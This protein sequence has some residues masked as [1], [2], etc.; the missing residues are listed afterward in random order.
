VARV[1]LLL[2]QVDRLT[3]IV[4]MGLER[5]TWPPPRPEDVDLRALADRVVHFLEPSFAASE[6]TVSLV[7]TGGWSNP[8]RARCDPDM[9][10]QILLNLLKNA[11][12]AARPAG[13][14]RVSVGAVGDRAELLVADDGPGLSREMREQLFSPFA[15]TKA[16]G[17]G[18]GLA[19]SRRLARAHDGELELVP[20]ESGVTWRLLLPLTDAVPETRP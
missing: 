19:V 20:T 6:V 3:T 18:L 8:V 9:V 17:T 12:E 1:D 11:I 4:R 5:S 7:P 13:H 15:T 10:E 14:V 16:G 2:D